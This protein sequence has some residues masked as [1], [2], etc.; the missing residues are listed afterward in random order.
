MIIK[1]KHIVYCWISGL[2]LFRAIQFHL[3][4][5]FSLLISCLNHC[6]SLL[7]GCLLSFATC[8]LRVIK[9]KLSKANT[10]NGKAQS[11]SWNSSTHCSLIP[12][13]TSFD[14]SNVWKFY[15]V[16]KQFET[17][18]KVKALLTFLT[19]KGSWHGYSYVNVC[20]IRWWKQVYK[21]FLWLS[22]TI[23]MNCLKI[24]VI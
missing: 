9:R 7:F 6:Y 24:L 13:Q 4:F 22:M 17:L 11:N 23:S 16:R 12:A 21:Y 14:L 19:V 1:Y 2:L 8:S 10:N 18:P 5:H 15:E 3:S 20:M